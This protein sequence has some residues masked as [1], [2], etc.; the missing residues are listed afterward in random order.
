MDERRSKLASASPRDEPLPE[1][2]RGR[3]VGSSTQRA[4]D[5]LSVSSKGRTRGSKGAG[6]STQ[7][8][9]LVNISEIAD[10]LGVTV[11]HVRQLVAER[12]IPY[13]KWGKLLRFDPDEISS[14]LAG[15]SVEPLLRGRPGRRAI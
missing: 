7:L 1:A 13:V 2:A 11:R 12:R 3:L 4:P 15:R 14:W 9:R 10:H 5:S 8:P 6:E